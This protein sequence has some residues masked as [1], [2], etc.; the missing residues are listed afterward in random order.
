MIG[1]NNKNLINISGKV[2]FIIC[3]IGSITS[4]GQRP[5]NSDTII[6]KSVIVNEGFELKFQECPGAGYSWSLSVPFDTTILSIRQLSSELMEGN[7]QIVR[8][9]LQFDLSLIHI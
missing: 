3:L 8:N 7:Y 5:I 1:I 6:R 2:L 9:D 4:L